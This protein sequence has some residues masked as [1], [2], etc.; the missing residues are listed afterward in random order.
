MS[1]FNE[2]IVLQESCEGIII[3]VVYIYK[4]DCVM[5]LQII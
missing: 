2:I 5:K 1:A 4:M 3:N